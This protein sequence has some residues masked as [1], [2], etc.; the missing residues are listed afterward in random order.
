[1]N[2]TQNEIRELEIKLEELSEKQRILDDI[3]KSRN[4]DPLP[5]F[6]LLF[7]SMGQTPPPESPPPWEIKEITSPEMLI[8]EM[9]MLF[10]DIKSN[11]EKRAPQPKK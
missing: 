11:F 7:E 1:M 5:P 4:T 10:D 6:R 2:I 9:E 3:F 8:S